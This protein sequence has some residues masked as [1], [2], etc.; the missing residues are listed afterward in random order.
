[1]QTSNIAQSPKHGFDSE[2]QR[3]VFRCQG[4]HLAVCTR[5]TPGIV[6]L[7]TL[8]KSSVIPVKNRRSS[9]SLW[10]M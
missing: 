5:H 8:R 7:E 2:R 4:F 9:A 10:R 1:M 3:S 6:A